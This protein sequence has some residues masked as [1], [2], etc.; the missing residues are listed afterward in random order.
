MAPPKTAVVPSYDQ[1]TEKVNEYYINEYQILSV[2]GPQER[3]LSEKYELLLEIVCVEFL[4]LWY[5][6]DEHNKSC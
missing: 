6:K 4:F 3:A 1:K 2:T 5:K